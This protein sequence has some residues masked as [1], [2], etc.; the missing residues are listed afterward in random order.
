M[1]RRRASNVFSSLM[2]ITLPFLKLLKYAL[3]VIFNG[4][5]HFDSFSAQNYYSE[6]FF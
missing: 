4:N 3:N 1:R 2:F 5:M 6:I